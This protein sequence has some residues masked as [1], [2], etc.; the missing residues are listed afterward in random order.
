MKVGLVRFVDR[1]VGI[2]LCWA[3]SSA[4][5]L[6]PWRPQPMPR[7]ILM[8]KW[9]GFG[10][11]IL[12][13]PAIAAMRERFPE[14]EITFVTLS[15]NKGLLER[16]PMVD[17]VYYFN[18]TSVR[19]VLGETLRL[20]RFLRRERFDVLVDFE[21]F[22]RYSAIM[23][24]LSGVPMRIG[25]NT[26]G[27]LR[28][29]VYTHPVDYRDGVHMAD[30]FCDLARA[31]G[32]AP[33]PTELAP[34]D[35]SDEDHLR[36]ERYM[37]EEGLQ[38]KPFVVIHPGTGDNAPQRR[39]PAERFAALADQ[40]VRDSGMAVVLSGSPKEKD[41]V[42]AVRSRMREA[43]SSTAG[44][45]SLSGFAALL[46]RAQL[47]VCSD[48][49]PVHL[50]AALRVPAV[51]FYGPNDPKLYGPVGEGHSII[52]KGLECSPCITNLNDKTTKCPHGNCIQTISVEETYLAIQRYPVRR[53]AAE[54]AADTER[55]TVA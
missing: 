15:A 24:G 8:M 3:V 39:W 22:S 5:R 14:A 29:G 38:G 21:Q 42:E 11:L 44:R 10:N 30:V 28:D 13:S 51:A 33:E 26:P 45:L 16:Y 35:L 20:L 54:H 46:Q 25:Y 32:G 48:T 34:F 17:R 49:G 52:Y 12:A 37:D 55:E 7:K 19:S 53:R 47:I 23:S 2:P 31:V 18:V 1:K 50:A 4:L 36:A 41:L 43:S 40:M 9:V 6:C 27:Q